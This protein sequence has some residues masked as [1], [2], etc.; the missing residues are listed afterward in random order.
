[1]Q[2]YTNLAFMSFYRFVCEVLVCTF[3]WYIPHKYGFE[4][5]GIAKNKA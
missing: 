3:T 4:R 1:M 5:R 2:S